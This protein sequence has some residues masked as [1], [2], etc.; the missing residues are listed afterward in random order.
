VAA[1]FRA[2]S[3][4]A[5]VSQDWQAARV[6]AHPLSEYAGVYV[7]SIATLGR[8]RVSLEEGHLAIDYLNGLPPLLPPGFSFVFEPGAQRARYVVTPIGVGE[9]A[10]DAG[11]AN[12]MTAALP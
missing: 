4:F 1:G 11:A 6:P 10:A 2:L 9:R 5:G 8:L 7:D 3:T 12:A